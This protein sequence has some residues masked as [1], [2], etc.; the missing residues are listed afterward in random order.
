MA[1]SLKSLL[2]KINLVDLAVVLVLIAVLICLMKKM[3]VVEGLCTVSQDARDARPTAISDMAN[4][5]S[6]LPNQGRECTNPMTWRGCEDIN[7]INKCGINMCED[8]DE[9]VPQ[10][11][12]RLPSQIVPESRRG[13]RPGTPEGNSIQPIDFT[14]GETYSDE[15]CA[16]MFIDNAN[17]YFDRANT[18]SDGLAT[19]L[20]ADFHRINQDGT[21]CGTPCVNSGICREYDETENGPEPP[22]DDYGGGDCTEWYL[23]WDPD[24][25]LNGI[26]NN[27]NI[28]L[29]YSN[30]RESPGYNPLL[31]PLALE[32]ICGQGNEDKECHTSMACHFWRWKNGLSSE[33]PTPS[34]PSYIDPEDI[35]EIID[36]E[37][38][39]VPIDPEVFTDQTGNCWPRCLTNTC[40]GDGSLTSKFAHCQDCPFC[41]TCPSWCRDSLS[42]NGRDSTCEGRDGPWC[43]GCSFCQE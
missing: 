40:R 31:A 35:P 9:K 26:R 42:E 36:P 28:S 14:S 25:R 1:K 38:F 6:D 37:T 19:A 29:R 20:N 30:N 27:R 13:S 22:Y 7:G 8:S 10:F 18:F 43:G 39:N 33:V 3:N 16:T 17:Y 32:Y 11:D 34:D 21:L 4:I 23:T 5:C 24:P 2:S 15:R 12:E 41:G